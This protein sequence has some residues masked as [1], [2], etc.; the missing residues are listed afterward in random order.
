MK[1]T[2]RI[3]ALFILA[4]LIV[5]LVADSMYIIYCYNKLGYIDTFQKIAFPLLVLSNCFAGKIFDKIQ[6]YSQELNKSKDELQQIFDSVDAALWS[7]EI[8]TNTLLVSAGIEKIYGVSRQRFLDNPKVWEEIVHP[9]DIKLVKECNE[10]LFSGISSC[11]VY[12]IM[13]KDGEVRWVR[14]QGT[15][16]F[17]SFGKLIKLNGAIFDITDTKKA[18]EKIRQLAYYDN[19]TGLPNRNMLNNYFNKL[20]DN[21]KSEKQEIG[22]M[23]L[24]LD[25]FKIIND[26]MGHAFGD[27]VLQQFSKRLVKC[28][29]KDDMVSRYGGDEFIILL[30][31]TDQV[32]ATKVAQRIIDEFSHPL[33]INK[34]KIFS[35]PSIG[36]SLYPESG[37]DLE[38]LIKCADIAMFFAKEKGKN[39][40]QFYVSNQ[41]KN[42]SK[43]CI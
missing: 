31:D 28:V 3:F 22:V 23:F 42:V 38:T 34:H 41:G 43:K 13:R 5:L 24:D 32:E 21:S 35:T 26:T 29:S 8:H 11:V 19:L 4:T 1:Y 9:E 25:R 18:E 27:I 6:F 33:M 12:R 15:P 10:K 39:N 7:F 37:E 16:I 14:D 36:I 20:L 17:D 40:Y 30:K 2:C